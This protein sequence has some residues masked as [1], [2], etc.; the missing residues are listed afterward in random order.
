MKNLYLIFFIF[1]FLTSCKEKDH[2]NSNSNQNLHTF[3]NEFLKRKDLTSDD[4]YQHILKLEK[5]VRKETNDEGLIK[6]LKGIY[7]A[8]KASFELSEHYLKKV[9]Q[10]PAVQDSV[11]DFAY[12]GLGNIY[13]HKGKYPEALLNYQNSLKIAN[14]RNDTIRIAGAYSAIAQMN[15]EKGDAKESKKNIEKVFQLLKN[16]KHE[17]AYLIAA[18]TLANVEGMNNNFEEALKIDEKGLKIC[19]SIKNEEAKVTFLDNKARCYMMMNKLDSAQYYFEKNLVIDKKLNRI[20]WI[21]DSYINLAE[22]SM[23]KKNYGAAENYLKA[24]IEILSKSTYVKNTLKAYNVLASIYEQQG[25]YKEAYAVKNDYNKLYE[26]IINEKNQ[27]S[28]NEF[29]VI[30]ETE[31]KEKQILEQKS[32]IF[33]RNVAVFSLLGLLLLGVGY[34]RNYQNRQKIKL[35]KE[36]L[37]QQDLATKAVMDAEDNERKRMAIHLHDGVGQLLTAT[38]MNLEVLDEYK[39]DEIAFGNV[40]K[41]TKN[42]LNEAMSEVRTLSHQIMPNML[43]KNSLSNALKDLIEKSNSPKL[44]INLKID[45]LK[46]N[47]DENIQIVMFRVIQEC[48]NN[49]IKH[50]NASEVIIQVHQNDQ[51]ISA[52]FQDN[53]KGFSIHELKSDGMG[54]ENIRSRIK[55]LKGK[56]EI[57]SEEG[58]GTQIHVKIPLQNV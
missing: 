31:N 26:K 41:K 19:D 32:K 40:V 52:A 46:D 29:N 47:L 44:H 22:V 57:N 13:K 38:N 49:T 54:I 21:A 51:E 37:H 6:T 24:S 3:Y 8:R 16:K 33:Q 9:I 34:Y 25:K 36:I 50:A 5:S 30:Y 23:L 14:K 58:R 15:S 39:N 20:N 10:S 12:I 55:F 28:F 11:K 43:I 56:F 42:I 48:I 18:H 4:V 2:K 53:G 45:G 1:F 17:T 35:Q 27:T 7:F